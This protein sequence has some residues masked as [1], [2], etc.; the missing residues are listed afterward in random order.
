[1]HLL[2]VASLKNRALIALVTICAVL[3][4][5]IAMQSL[6]T[7]LAPD[8]EF[9][10]L[11]VVTEY[12][13]ASPEVVAND[14]TDVV[15]RAL[16]TV[17]GLKETIGTSSQGRST[18]SAEFEYGTDLA[19]T[20]QKVQQALSRVTGALP[21]GVETTVVA[22]SITDFPIIQLSVAIGDERVESLADRIELDAIPRLERLEGVRSVD[23]EGVAG[24]RVTIVADEEELALA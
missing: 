21:D 5:G 3:F 4:G 17:P 10:Q 12:E 7:E 1:M 2:A 11:A 15:E 20:E 8:I 22:G 23:L 9:P 13:G 24:Q 18:V 19:T 16:Q 14:V 6:R